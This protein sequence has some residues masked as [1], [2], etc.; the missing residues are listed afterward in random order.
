LSR[1]STTT[2]RSDCRSTARP[3]PGSPVI[4]RHRFPPPRR[5]RGRDGSPQFPGRPSTRSTPNYAGGSL[6]A[7]SRIQGAFHGLRRCATGSAPSLPAKGG[8]LD[9]ACSGFTHVADRAVA[10]TP[11][12]TRPLD[13]ARGHRY[14][15]PR[16]LP[17]PDSHRQAILNLSLGLRHVELLSIT[18]PSS[19]GAL[20][21]SGTERVRSRSSLAEAAAPLLCGRRSRLPRRR[22]RDRFAPFQ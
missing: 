7:R 4:G 12:R 16:R 8:P 13:H 1:R 6:G 18:R 11:L 10:S 17:G 20:H 19:L 21:K 15:G 9:D 2:T 22:G 5:R 3:F 14:Q